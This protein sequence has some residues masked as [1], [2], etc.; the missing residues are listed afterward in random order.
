MSSICPFVSK[1][2][3][4]NPYVEAPEVSTFLADNQRHFHSIGGL[5]S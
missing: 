4:R 3:S 2:D 1:P 5:E